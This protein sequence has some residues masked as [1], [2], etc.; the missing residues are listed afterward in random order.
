MGERSWGLRQEARHPRAFLLNGMINT[1][2]L[3][4][5]KAGGR[6]GDET[7]SGPSSTS[8][9]RSETGNGIS[10]PAYSGGENT[11]IR[12]IWGPVLI[13]QVEKRKRRRRRVGS[14]SVNGREGATS[15]HRRGAKTS[16][17]GY[18]KF[19][20]GW[21]VKENRCF[22]APSMGQRKGVGASENQLE[23]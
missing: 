23:T 17:G 8:A 13:Y 15:L 3:Q 4:K 22:T 19:L 7:T 14:S 11:E 9:H 18:L 5:M 1:N 21:G 20:I 10:W 16:G 2:A 12:N 6:K